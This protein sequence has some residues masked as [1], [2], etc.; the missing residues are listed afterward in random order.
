M[1]RLGRSVTVVITYQNIRKDIRASVRCPVVG[2]K[3]KVVAE[4]GEYLS[5]RIGNIKVS[6]SS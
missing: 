1:E 6:D 4:D 2:T 5:T 3:S